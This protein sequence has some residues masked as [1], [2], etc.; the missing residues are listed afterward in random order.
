MGVF[1]RKSHAFGN[2]AAE[3]CVGPFETE[4]RC[5]AKTRAAES[6]PGGHYHGNEADEYE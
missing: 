5:R 1:G 6:C 4:T 3:G 2:A